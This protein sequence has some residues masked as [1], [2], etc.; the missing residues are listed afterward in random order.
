MEE[1]RI[2]LVEDDDDRITLTRHALGDLEMDV[3]VDVARTCEAA[4]EKLH[5]EPVDPP[6][7][8]LLDLK[9]EGSSGFDVLERVRGNPQTRALPVVVLTSSR[10]DAD[11]QASYELGANSYVCKPVDFEDFR[12]QLHRIGTYWLSVNEVPNEAGYRASG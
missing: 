8:V 6:D 7:L 1:H 3:R 4:L 11:C 9:L 10:E 2:L 12:E 5:G